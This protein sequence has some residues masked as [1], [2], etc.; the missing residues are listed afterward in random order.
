MR[1]K[2]L[3]QT[4]YLTKQLE[5]QENQFLIE[6]TDWEEGIYWCKKQSNGRTLQEISFVIKRDKSSPLPNNLTESFNVYPNP[7]EDYFFIDFNIFNIK[8]TNIQITDVKGSVIKSLS[9]ITNNK[10]VSVNTKSWQH[11]IYFVSLL[12]N[13]AVI[14]TVKVVVK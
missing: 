3:F 14:K 7:T 8:N 9:V 11:G 5:T 1:I 4:P 2:L 12:S 6:C 10:K 13:N